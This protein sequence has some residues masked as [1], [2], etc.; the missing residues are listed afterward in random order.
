MFKLGLARDAEL[1][2]KGN[3]VQVANARQ[4]ASSVLP[5]IEG[6]RRAGARMLTAIAH[7]HMARGVPAPCG[8]DRWSP[9]QVRRTLLIGSTSGGG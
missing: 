3:A 8:G 7:A 2:A 6:A 4:R 5:Y 9:A 1:S